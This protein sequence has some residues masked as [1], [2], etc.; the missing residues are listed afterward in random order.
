ML[1][2]KLFKIVEMA[3]LFNKRM[4]SLHSFQVWKFMKVQHHDLAFKDSGI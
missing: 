1:A 4:F 3:T 2:F